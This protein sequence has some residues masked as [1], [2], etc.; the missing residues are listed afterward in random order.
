MRYLSAARRLRLTV[1]LA[2]STTLALLLVAVSC[3]PVQRADE[4]DPK[5]VEKKA[6]ELTR[7]ELTEKVSS[8]E[9]QLGVY[10]GVLKQKTLEYWQAVIQ[11]IGFGL[12]GLALLLGILA[13]FLPPKKTLVAAAIVCVGAAALCFFFAEYVLPWM[14]AIGGIILAG[15]IIGA[16]VMI[17]RNWDDL[18][19]SFGV[20]SRVADR[21]GDKLKGE[22]EEAKDKIDAFT[23]ELA[24][25]GKLSR[26]KLK[27]IRDTLREA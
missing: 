19:V 13:A 22:A 9:L 18:K 3:T 15:I 11:G 2:V 20:A 27:H 24:L 23:A 25:T 12:L 16:A 10:R 5:S 17:W 6:R 26:E 8:L 21:L 7:E 1:P 4:T 14:L